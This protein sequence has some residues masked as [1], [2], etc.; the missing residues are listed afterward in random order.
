MPLFDICHQKRQNADH[1]GLIHDIQIFADC[2][3]FD[4]QGLSEFLSVQFYL[5]VQN[6]DEMWDYLLTHDINVNIL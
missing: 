4:I 2:R 5:V 6:P 1:K 3:M